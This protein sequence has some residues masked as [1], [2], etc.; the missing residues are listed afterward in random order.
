M[1]DAKIAALESISIHFEMTP[2]KTYGIFAN[3]TLKAV[4]KPNYQLWDT[5]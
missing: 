4:L 3:L 1:Y 5:F 2:D